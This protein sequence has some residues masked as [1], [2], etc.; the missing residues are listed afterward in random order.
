VNS[1]SKEQPKVKTMTAED[2]NRALRARRLTQF[3]LAEATGI[4]LVYVNKVL[5]GQ[6]QPNPERKARMEA[7]IAALRLDEPAPN[8]RNSV[9][10][11]IP[12]GEES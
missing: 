8:A 3:D 4:P 11:E 6:L 5:L 12:T 7:A 9:V 1:E 2:V 10:F